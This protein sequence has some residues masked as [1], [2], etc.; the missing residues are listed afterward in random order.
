MKRD[1]EALSECEISQAGEEL[2]MP[3]GEFV[4]LFASGLPGFW[5]SNF[6]KIGEG[7]DI[8]RHR[9]PSGTK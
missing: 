2:M 1:L 5:N 3:T 9:N 4:A 6:P 7:R 8:R